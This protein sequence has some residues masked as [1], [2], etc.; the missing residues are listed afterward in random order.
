[1]R[2][3]SGLAA[4]V[5]PFIAGL[6]AAVAAEL[7]TGLLLY[8]TA[9]FLRALTL[10]LAVLLGSL[11]LGL[12]TAPGGDSVVESLRRRW[13]LTL[14]SFAGAAAVSGAWS[15]RGGLA[16]DGL[17]RGIGLAFLAAVPLY[18]CGA[19][20]AGI[21]SVE[22]PERRSNV[23]ATAAAGAA[24]GALITG[25]VLVSWLLPVSIYLFC[26]I[27]LSGAALVHGRVL[28]GHG[29][30]HVLATLQ[31]RFGEV[32]VEEVVRAGTPPRRLLLENGRL[33]GAEDGA[34]GPGRA[35]EAGT[36]ELLRS[37]PPPHGEAMGRGRE[38]GAREADAETAPARETPGA[39]PT[40]R[41]LLAGGGAMIVARVLL[42]EWPEG[43]VEVFERNEV[44]LQAAR[45]HFDAPLGE[46]RVAVLAQNPWDALASASG[47]WSW[48]IVDAAAVAPHDPLPELGAELL[49]SL[50][51]RI[52][53]TGALVVGGVDAMSARGMPL[54]A[55]LEAARSVFGTVAVYRGPP[56]ARPAEVRDGSAA[57]GG[58]LLLVCVPDGVRLPEAL[59]GMTLESVV[60]GAG[61]P[62]DSA[63]DAPA[64][65]AEEPRLKPPS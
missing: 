59:P 57:P 50:R 65:D 55:L 42:A 54:D 56:A 21:A 10:I 3:P 63:G 15:M 9:G 62:P 7:A 17:A 2:T 23:A 18:A 44:V 43:Q 32:R 16:E 49:A 45:E 8:A 11:A 22:A 6:A 36:L 39:Q 46:R 4:L 58:E 48:V 25:L 5:P 20:L 61:P 33:R 47:P 14:V 27:L 53:P 34:G 26:L 40:V 64:S 60:P 52:A 1:M 24:A 38:E 28:S 51:R 35:W 19:L 29:E 31:S 12:W 13:L 41:V 37:W 30:R